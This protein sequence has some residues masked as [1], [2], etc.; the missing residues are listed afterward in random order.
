MGRTVIEH[1]C[2][3]LR[4]TTAIAVAMLVAPP[5]A[6][7]PAPPVDD[8]FLPAPA[9]PGPPLPTRQVVSC[10]LPTLSTD[11]ALARLPF[12]TEL[13]A[14]AGQLSTGEGQVVAILDTGVSRHRQLPDL[15]G[16]GD[17]TSTGDGTHD[18]DG[19]GTLVAGIIA[20]QADP[21]DENAFVGLAPGVTVMSI[22]QTT[23]KFGVRAGDGAGL[24]D[25]ITLAMAVRT[26]ADLG[27]TVIN[28]SAV[29]CE[30]GGYIDDRA[31]GAAVAYA[32][33][34]KD[35]V[36]VSAAG[37]INAECPANSTVSPGRYDDYVL[38]VGSVGRDGSA[39]DFT[40]A[41]PW[42]DVAAP[43][44]AVVS[45]DPDG[46]GVVDTKAASDGA[47]PLE[48]TSY[49]APVVS[50]V[51]ALV[52]SRFPDL[53]A[54]E[55]AQRIEDTAR[56]G[57][58]GWDPFVGNG[59]VDPLAAISVETPTQTPTTTQTPRPASVTRSPI[60]AP[61]DYPAARFALLGVAVCLGALAA[62]FAARSVS[63]HHL[64]RDDVAG[65]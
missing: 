40:L 32:V 30:P 65:D 20:A 8:S 6:A 49:A 12:D 57:P 9:E 23:T 14:Q 48:G 36:V 28:I 58:A 25:V 7:D 29:A 21:A 60:V 38:T 19:H 45:L 16:A 3:A 4:L 43:G 5:A 27:A 47:G 46:T 2:T 61:P 10:S 31:L 33:E 41:G 39:S 52:R 64:A 15:V 54:R 13:L 11:P 56:P 17:Y 51:A 55:V 37:N 35:A 42:V 18:C 24:G 22:R 34:I 59:V 44:E 50:A 53:T 62:F 26:A 1:R 63:A